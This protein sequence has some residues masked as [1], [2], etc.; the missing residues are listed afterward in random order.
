ML[1][2]SS[3]IIEIINSA[4]NRVSGFVNIEMVVAYFQI[5]KVLIEKLQEGSKRAEYGEKL[6]QQ[7]SIELTHQLGRGYSVQNLERMR[8]FYMLYSKSSNQLRKSD[9]LEKS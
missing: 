9:Y 4:R 2:L 7:V 1:S 5:G 3:Q 8:N 6:L